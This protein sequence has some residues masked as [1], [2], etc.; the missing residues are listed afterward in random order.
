MKLKLKDPTTA[1]ALSSFDH[2][3]PKIFTDD[4]ATTAKWGGNGDKSCFTK[5]RTWKMWDLAEDGA[6][7]KSLTAIRVVAHQH[8]AYI[9]RELSHCPKMRLL[10][11]QSLSDS[12]SFAIGLFQWFDTMVKDFIVARLSESKAYHIA[13]TLMV[14]VFE[15]IDEPRRGATSGLH[16][17]DLASM[18]SCIFWAN[19]QC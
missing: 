12:Q 3:I 15:Y 6:R 16:P 11:L 17:G 10:A 9:E 18:S 19:L 13:T 8:A 4:K 14:A 7:D 5:V 1:S 2:L